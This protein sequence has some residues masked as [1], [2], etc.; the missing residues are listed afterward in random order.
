MKSKISAATLVLLAVAL[1]AT[2]S[3][4]LKPAPYVPGQV[5][6]KFRP[7]TGAAERAK[8]LGTARVKRRLPVARTVLVRLP[9][10]ESVTAAVR[11]LQRDPRVQYA[12]PNAYVHAAGIIPNDSLY[13]KQWGMQA[14][15][16]EEAW[17]T[18]TGSP[19]VKV[20][21]VD[22][23]IN[24]DQPDLQPNIWRNPGESGAG[25][26]DNGVDD[27]GDGFVDDW[28]GWDFVQQDNNPEDNFG[29][30]THVSGTIAARG[31][32]G[33]GVAGVAWQANLIPVRVLDNVGAGDCSGTAA[34]MA[35]AVQQGA[36]IVNLSLGSRQRCTAEED[37]ISANPDVLF[38]V[39]ALNE[40]VDVDADPFYPCAFPDANIVCVGASDQS[41]DLAGFSNYG[42]KSVDLAAPGVGVISTYMK[43]DP[44]QSLF[45]DGF[46]ASLE[47]RWATGGSP[48]T[49]TRTPFTPVRSGGFSLSNSQLGDYGPDNDN[50]AEL[51]TGLDLTGRR[52]CAASVWLRASLPRLDPSQPTEAQDRIIA[53]TSP[54]GV[55][56]GRRPSV[57]IGSN[58]SFDRWVIDLSELEGRPH[59]GLRFRLAT[60][61]DGSG[62]GVALDDL[63]ILCVPPRTDYTGADDEFDY[64]FGTS[65]AAP[66]VAGTAVLLLA[67]DP[68]LTPAELKARLLDTVDPEPGLAGRTVT[69]G[70]LNAAR[71]VAP[72]PVQQQQ[73]QQQPPP[74]TNDPP[75]VQW[76]PGQPQ[77]TPEDGLKIDL[78]NL[79]RTVK[80]AG[81]RAVLRSS[82]V[83]A[84]RLHAFGPGR[85]V[86]TVKA[87]AAI[88]RG[89]CA[90][91]RPAL[92]SLKAPLT[93]RG[94]A[95]VKSARRLRLTLVLAFHP[96]TGPTLRRKTAVSVGR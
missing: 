5:I 88:A 35:Y 18:T 34:G 60:N 28:R 57:L 85:F 58:S 75:P 33:I 59:G 95:L 89:T 94:R 66:H 12:E 47:D 71:A 19:D 80:R 11:R 84:T 1:P 4:A 79:A 49:W 92:C 21:V 77:I 91:D 44:K 39:A 65:M 56:W 83:R 2:A 64:D 31:D 72:P 74:P 45:T 82:G 55:T 40:G 54:D 67:E 25:R 78:A 46:E 61:G 48:D 93:R 6:V 30:G 15:H 32:N 51:K 14:I 3:A 69:G 62:K 26:E 42:A 50:W 16:A 70:R 68:T 20:A 76:N 17:D 81:L 22:G 9:P 96:R 10:D 41:D 27:D 24:F 87:R 7:G 13:S 29:H 52:D 23:G 36:R 8:T 38:V 63:E 43:W 53:E 86:L 73:Q 90:T 37:V